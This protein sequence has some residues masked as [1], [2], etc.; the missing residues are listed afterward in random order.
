MD[1]GQTIHKTEECK[2]L[3][4]LL[5][6]QT[7][8]SEKQETKS[9]HTAKENEICDQNVLK[10]KDLD[11]ITEYTEEKFNKF[12]LSKTSLRNDDRQQLEWTVQKNIL[13]EKTGFMQTFT[14][15]TAIIEKQKSPVL[16]EKSKLKP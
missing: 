14:T 5:H 6:E 16:T 9:L 11:L 7:E 4:L 10:Q 1:T 15:T 3:E 12:D 2:D 8:I 13:N